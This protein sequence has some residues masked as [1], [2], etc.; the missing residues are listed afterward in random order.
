MKVNYSIELDPQETEA[1]CNC[2]TQIFGIYAKSEV[3]CSMKPALAKAVVEAVSEL[4]SEPSK[5]ERHAVD[6]P[7]K[8]PAKA[9]TTKAAPAVKKVPVEKH[10]RDF[11]EV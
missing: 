6:E 9:K 3:A 4:K 7:A 11:N 5:D 8:K 10:K 2:I 1:I